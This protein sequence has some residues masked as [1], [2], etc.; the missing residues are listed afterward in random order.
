VLDSETVAAIEQSRLAG[1][2]GDLLERLTADAIDLSVPAG[3]LVHPDVDRPFTDLIVRGLVR[4]FASS[5]EGSRRVSLSVIV[6]TGRERLPTEP[7]R[8]PVR[9]ELTSALRRGGMRATPSS[10]RFARCPYHAFVIPRA[11]WSATTGSGR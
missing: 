5:A 1:L 10:R 8:P 2:P 4:V 9:G 3:S 11:T 7:A 6:V